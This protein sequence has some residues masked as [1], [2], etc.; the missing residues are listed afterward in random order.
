MS[1]IPVFT[2]GYGSRS[3]EDLLDLLQRHAIE[4]LLDVRSRPYSKNRPEYAKQALEQRLKGG[5]MR[6]VFMGD[7]LGGLP[8]GVAGGA[9][10]GADMAALARSPAFRRGLDRLR[11]AYA[12][13]RRVALL[14][15]EAR[16]EDCHRAT[17]IGAGLAA[18]GVP[19]THIDEHGELL[20][21]EAVLARREHVT[22][23]LIHMEPPPPEEE[24]ESVADGSS[25]PP[26]D[27]VPPP[28]DADMP[29]DLPGGCPAEASCWPEPVLAS[30]AVPDLSRFIGADPASVLKQV[31]GY[32]AF[33]PLQAEVVA[34]VLV[35]QDTLAIMPTGSGKSLCYQLPALLFPGVS[36][37]V[38]PLIA[39]MED[40]VMQARELGLPAAFLNS[41][42]SSKEYQA[43][44]AEVRAGRVK[45]LYAAPE[46]LL[47]PG[48]L[49]LL[50]SVAVD[51]LTID[52]AH[53]ISE[54]G[55]DF[56]PE[57][58]Q[59]LDVRRRLP[60]A[61]CLAVTATATER[62][63]Q[64]IKHTLGISEAQTHLASFNRDNLYLEVVPKTQAKSKAMGQLLA[65]VRERAD[66]SGIIYCATRRQVD[67]LSEALRA[68]GL[69]V[70][71]YHAGLDAPTRMRHQR[72]F[73]RDQARIM[74]ATVAFGM[75]IN[76][77]DIRY[78]VHY[79]LPKNLE[80]YYQ[81]VGRAGRDGLRA[82][83][84]LL[85]SYGAVQTAVSFIKKMDP[86]QQKS[87]RMQLEAMVGYA[88]SAVCR[89]I[90]LLGYFNESYPSG[91]CEMCDNCCTPRQELADM[92][93][94]AQK[95]LSCVKRTGELFGA[96][97]IID[98]LRGSR[99][100]KVLGRG[101]DA[102]STYNIG[103]EYSRKQW[104]HLA[105]QFI[106][107]GLLIQDMEHGGLRLGQGALAVFRGRQVLG[108]QPAHDR[109]TPVAP[110]SGPEGEQYDSKLFAL[111]RA[112]RKALAEA[113]NV[114]PY[115]VFS[116]RTLVE[117]ATM[118]PQTPEALAKVH[119]VGETKLA[120][121]AEEFLPVL[122][123]YC[124]E[125]GIAE[126]SPTGH[127]P[128]P[129]KQP[130]GPGGRTLEVLA[131]HH[132][133]RTIAQISQIFAV[134]PGTVVHHLWQASQAGH[135]VRGDTLAG[136]IPLPSEQLLQVLDVFA[137]HGTERLRP[138]FDALDGNVT[139]DDLHMVRLYAVSQK[140][141]G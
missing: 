124:A 76:K 4:Y 107:Q 29:C 112:R 136:Q 133:G 33:R 41:T 132:Q 140:Q 24:G 63:R 61:V 86:A 70:L 97:H 30:G 51:C 73:I 62:V 119:G 18:V 23:R 102:L 91:S 68:Q 14:C 79:D 39:L 128:A 64:D 118:F 117:M 90:P 58:R 95:F 15:C 113:A 87:A 17:L 32:D 78:V 37:V 35:R 38:S 138:V 81:Q 74:V 125:W 129:R 71:P 40:Q 99:S 135:H 27:D 130:E 10:S 42:L 46:T 65:F 11:T 127:V 6:Y 106:Q 59:L 126:Q 116:D 110:T 101:H 139:Y 7:D 13:Q 22:E 60:G 100:E 3:I 77:S 137:A 80:S 20:S 122:R 34:D 25:G 8:N 108:I 9:E 43:V 111:L 92:T 84:L 48:I 1:L 50:E 49:Q 82:D 16:P 2:I 21:Q 96:S 31:F 105:R 67:V 72:R 103:Q 47:Q 54:W 52:E 115:V 57:Y 94:A 5:G 28:T 44:M 93:V 19:V 83:C 141:G 114:P 69:S 109:P 120:R 56:R 75:G 36:V 66:Q 12:Q 134:K 104:Q 85:F 55:H 98:V 89:R 121:Y 131:L 53:C 26:G 45:L 123:D 88:E